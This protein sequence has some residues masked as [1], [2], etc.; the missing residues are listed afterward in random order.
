M[1]DLLLFIHPN[2]IER[3][4]RILH[5]KGP[6]LRLIEGKQHA[7][8]LA[9]VFTIHQSFCPFFS[10][11]G[12]LDMDCHSTRKLNGDE[13]IFGLDAG[14]QNHDQSKQLDDEPSSVHGGILSAANK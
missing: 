11:I 8:V 12:D 14:R 13:P 4:L 2:D 10:C 6:G 9:Q 7:A 3:D 1:D 5:P